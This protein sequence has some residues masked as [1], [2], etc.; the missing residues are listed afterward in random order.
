M[1]IKAE[2]GESGEDRFY[3]SEPPK[4]RIK[5]EKLDHES[6]DAQH[7]QSF[8][9]SS[10]SVDDS[11][12][13]L[14]G[15]SGK[16]NTHPTKKKSL[17]RKLRKMVIHREPQPNSQ[18]HEVIILDSPIKTITVRKTKS[19]HLSPQK[20]CHIDLTDLPGIIDLTQSDNSNSDDCERSTSKS[21]GGT[22]NVKGLYIS[23]PLT[24]SSHQDPDRTP[25]LPTPKRISKFLNSNTTPIKCVSSFSRKKMLFNFPVKDEHSRKTPPLDSEFIAPNLAVVTENGVT[26]DIAN[27]SILVDNFSL[28]L[29]SESD[30]DL[31][32]AEDAEESANE[33]PA[34]SSGDS[35]TQEGERID[36]AVFLSDLVRIGDK[37]RDE[38]EILR[39]VGVES[40]EVKMDIKEEMTLESVVARGSVGGE[41]KE[42]M[43][44]AVGVTTKS[45]VEVFVE[46]EVAINDVINPTESCALQANV[47]KQNS[48][49]SELI[50]P[51][52]KGT[53]LLEVKIVMAERSLSDT[54]VS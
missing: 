35:G 27:G 4:G 36:S 32:S 1:L 47:V 24:L 23:P 53:P 42:V 11:V 41:A 43:G 33:V 34:P 12:V 46:K 26:P 25:E 15:V 19:S 7:R 18:P 52:W 3:L 48:N 30:R 38:L 39:D 49:K 21:K 54:K 50:Q 16:A 5:K 31:F 28:D 9:G 6:S 45:E 51:N 22:K 40:E 20:P 13:I 29:N 37:K 17:K 10:S 2:S 44:G 8:P 14:D